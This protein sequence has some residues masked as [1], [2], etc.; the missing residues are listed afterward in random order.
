MPPLCACSSPRFT[1]VRCRLN[2]ARLRR[3]VSLM[4]GSPLKTSIPDCALSEVCQALSPEIFRSAQ[5][6]PGLVA[7]AQGQ[8]ASSSWRLRFDYVKRD[9]GRIIW[10]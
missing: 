10:R 3:A 4:Q 2:Q 7:M 8:P 9:T 1:T 5:A 6:H